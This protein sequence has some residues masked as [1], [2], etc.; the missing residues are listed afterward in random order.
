MSKAMR[1]RHNTAGNRRSMKNTPNNVKTVLPT[2][3]PSIGTVT[4]GWSML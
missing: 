2:R 4:S 3:T 1:I